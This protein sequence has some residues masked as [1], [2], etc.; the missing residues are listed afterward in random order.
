MR[1][2]LS[3]LLAGFLIIAFAGEALAQNCTAPPTASTNE[4]QIKKGAAEALTAL[5]SE[6]SLTGAALK[7]AIQN[8]Q[9]MFRRIANMSWR[10]YC[11]NRSQYKLPQLAGGLVRSVLFFYLSGQ[12]NLARSWLPGARTQVTALQATKAM[13]EM[14]GLRLDRLLDTTASRLQNG[15]SASEDWRIWIGAKPG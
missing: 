10:A 12:A 6:A 13:P 15:T 2:R 9:K 3:I 1:P 5:K 4:Q 8:R 14:F 11:D 7:T